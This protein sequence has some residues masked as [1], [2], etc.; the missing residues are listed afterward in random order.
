MRQVVARA[1]RHAD[2]LISGSAAARDEVVAELELDPQRFS[3]VHHG[4]DTSRAGVRR[5]RGSSA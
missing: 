4:A 1:A 2:R 5:A 3:V